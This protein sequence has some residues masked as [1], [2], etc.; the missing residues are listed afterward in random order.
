M[1]EIIIFMGAV[2]LLVVV[3]E[4]DARRNPPAD[5]SI[6]ADD[7]AIRPAGLIKSVP[8]LEKRRLWFD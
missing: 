5:S 3:L 8:S 6:D 1:M 4:L 7:D 2:L